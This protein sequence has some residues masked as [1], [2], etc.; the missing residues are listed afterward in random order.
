MS[1]YNSLLGFAHFHFQLANTSGRED[2]EYEDLPLVNLQRRLR[3][4]H[5]RGLCA[6]IWPEAGRGGGGSV[7]PILGDGKTTV[8]GWGCKNCLLTI[9][10]KQI[11]LS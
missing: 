2:T 9:I 5:G 1:L 7:H 11:A 4:D 6:A 3:L 8:W 10:L